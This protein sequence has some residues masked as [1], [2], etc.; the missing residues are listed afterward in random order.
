MVDLIVRSK[1]KNNVPEGMRVSADLA[2]ALDKKAEEILKKASERAQANK[3]TTI[4][5]QD[6]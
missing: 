2:D 5:A 6:L 1:I 3:R 4:M